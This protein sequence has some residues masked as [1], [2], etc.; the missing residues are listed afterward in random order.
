MARS[1][2][3]TGSAEASLRTARP[4]SVSVR[5][6]LRR[7]RRRAIG[8]INHPSLRGNRRLSPIV[9][10]ST[11]TPLARSTNRVNV[12]MPTDTAVATGGQQALVRLAGGDDFVDVLGRSD[13]IRGR[14]LAFVA[15]HGAHVEHDRRS[16]GASAQPRQH[17][18]PIAIAVQEARL[19][20]GVVHARIRIVVL[21][22]R[23]HAFQPDARHVN[24]AAPMVDAHS[25]A[26]EGGCVQATRHR[27]G[28]SQP[29]CDE[30]AGI[31]A[32]PA[33]SFPLQ[34]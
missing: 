10:S 24:R 27:P 3:G 17:T 34:R 33:R 8:S 16:P 6:T 20:N 23:D 12:L 18:E 14:R 15:N 19:G 2:G 11:S 22:S 32:S 30:T 28:G 21:G 25:N 9:S 4:N 31:Y 7:P 26:H 1:A 5:S 13:R 29:H